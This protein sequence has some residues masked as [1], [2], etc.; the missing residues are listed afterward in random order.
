MSTMHARVTPKWPLGIVVALMAIAAGVA[1]GYGGKWIA[2]GVIVGAMPFALVPVL[3]FERKRT[4]GGHLS[5]EIPVFLVCFSELVWRARNAQDL[6]TNPL[7]PAGI[8]R[9]ACVSLAVA[10]AVITLLSPRTVDRV[11]ERGG[12]LSSAPFRLYALYVVVVFIGAPLS[13][14]P[15]VTAYRGFELAAGVLVVAAACYAFGYEAIDR[16]QKVLFWFIVG[17]LGVVWLEVIALPGKAL[18]QP[19]GPIPFQIQGVLPNVPSNTVGTYGVLLA[20]WS[21]AKLFNPSE[22]DLSRKTLFVLAGFGTVTLLAAQYRTGYAIFLAGIAILLVLRGKKLLAGVIVAGVVVA[23]LWGPTLLSQAEPYLLRGQSLTQAQQ[24]SGRTTW[25]DLAVPVWKQSPWLGKGLQT[26][27]R[28]EVLAAHGYGETSTIHGAW[29]E[30]LV[31]TG[32]IGLGLLVLAL[33]LTWARAIANASR[34]NGPIVPLLLLTVLTLRCVTGSSFELSGYT[35]VLF[36]VVAVTP[37]IGSAL[38]SR[39]GSLGR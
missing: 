9:L 16:I 23:T 10:L 35:S 19:D 5:L 36:L 22:R 31:G 27:T 21:M 28:F 6:Q 29:L 14:L 25:W 11:R 7:D 38:L 12:L 4:R 26:G 3:S 24:L 1:I 13:I 33:I 2:A 37:P 18:L 34:Q 20:L 17:L 8:F 39:T 32:V 15:L 30:A